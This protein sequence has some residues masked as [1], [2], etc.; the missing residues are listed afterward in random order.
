MGID[1]Q[2]T[3]NHGEAPVVGGSQQKKIELTVADISTVTKEAFNKLRGNIQLSGYDL[4]TICVTSAVIHEGKSLVAFRL[5]ESFAN[6]R[7]KTI[8]LDCD[9]RNSRTLS[10]YKVQGQVAGLSEFLTGQARLLDI[11]YKTAN[12]YLD[13]IFAGKAAPNP[14]ELFSGPLF[15]QL[16]DFL[17][18]YYAFVIVDTPPV[19]G[20]IDGVLIAKECDGTAL[21]VESG[22]TDRRQSMKAKQ[23]LEFAG[24]KLLGTVLNKVG[25]KKSGYGYGYG[26]FEDENNEHSSTEK[27]TRREKHRLFGKKH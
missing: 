22:V 8:Y 21:V 26:A 24:V 10:R 9:I 11:D 15:R 2:L 17:K 1:E 19:T 7:K 23:Q 6:L 14:S 18:K 3:N 12:P 27:A 20:I 4:K 13:V 16:L 5:A 25:T